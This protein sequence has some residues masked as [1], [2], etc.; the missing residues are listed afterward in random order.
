MVS[1]DISSLMGKKEQLKHDEHIAE[2]WKNFECKKRKQMLTLVVISL[3][4]L[5]GKKKKHRLHRRE[6]F[7]VLL[8]T[9]GLEAELFFCTQKS[10]TH[11]Q[12]RRKLP[13]SEC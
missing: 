2:V 13:V 6:Q 4:G 10:C 8:R 11:G 12:V 3:S 9:I 5:L 7:S 1:S